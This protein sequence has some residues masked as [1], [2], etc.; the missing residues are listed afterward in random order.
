MVG[1]LFCIAFCVWV[2]VEPAFAQSREAPG[3]NVRRRQAERA[4]QN[5]PYWDGFILKHNGKCNEAIV[6][7]TPLA[8]LGVGYEDAQTALGECHLQLAGFDIKTAQ[9]PTRAALAENQNYQTGLAWIGVAANAGHFEAQGLMVSLYAAGLG[10]SIKP[11]DGA[12]WA[13]LYLTNPSR[14]NLGVPILASAS[15]EHLEANISSDIW[16]RGKQKAR[17]WV[18]QYA[19]PPFETDKK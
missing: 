11:I 10:P 2:F 19:L 7:L 6:K 12:L 3:D 16:L 4:A 8:R 15:I 5:A 18:P 17:R 1:R 13:H 9:P 14:L